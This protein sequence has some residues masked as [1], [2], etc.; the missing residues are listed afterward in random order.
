MNRRT[1]E[2]EWIGRHTPAGSELPDMRPCQCGGAMSLNRHASKN[3]KRVGGWRYECARCRASV[4]A[5]PRG[6]MFSACAKA[7]LW[8]ALFVATILLCDVCVLPTAVRIAAPLCVALVFVF[9]RPTPTPSGRPS[10][11][12]GH[13]A[14]HPGAATDEPHADFLPVGQRPCGDS[15]T[16]WSM[17]QIE[18]LQALPVRRK[19]EIAK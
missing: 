2:N 13:P 15:P 12:G 16:E 4:P 18:R 5:S 8:T 10:V 9:T 17:N 7:L 11:P 19:E 3:P 6:R 14:A 1:L